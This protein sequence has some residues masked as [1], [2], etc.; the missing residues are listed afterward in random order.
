MFIPYPVVY[1]FIVD[2]TCLIWEKTCG[3]TG[4]CWLYDIDKFRYR[5]HGFT[6]AFSMIGSMFDLIV[7]M[8]ANRLKNM[9]E[10]EEDGEGEQ[11]EDIEADEKEIQLLNVDSPNK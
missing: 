8:Y 2:S 4:N 10:D 6:F 3:K 7:F 1:G 11:P 9:Y 5:L